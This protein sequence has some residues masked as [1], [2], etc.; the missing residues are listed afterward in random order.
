MAK[1]WER[2]YSNCLNPK[3]QSFNDIKQAFKIKSEN[4][5]GRLFKYKKVDVNSA[6]D[7]LDNVVRLSLPTDFNDPYDCAINYNEEK[8][9]KEIMLYDHEISNKSKSFLTPSE[10]RQIKRSDRPVDTF[11][12]IVKSL[13][14]EYKG[15]LN[16][17]FRK[18]RKMFKSLF[19][20]LDRINLDNWKSQIKISCFTENY[21]AKALPMWAYYGDNHKGYCLEYNFKEAPYY[22]NQ[23]FPVK[24]CN[25][26]FTPPFKRINELS[27]YIWPIISA[28]TKALNWKYEKEWR[29][30]YVNPKYE[31]VSIKPAAIYLGSNISNT[32][33]TKLIGVSKRRDLKIYKCRSKNGDFELDIEELTDMEISELI[34]KL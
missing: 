16:D 26:Y 18:L 20:T 5:P 30:I 29:L 23:L 13:E 25:H 21:P 22:S 2:Q 32:N 8:Q 33:M 11:L 1:N 7:I 10:I 9:F 27:K 14:P 31:V 12:E 6:K 28:T 34:N 3:C 24:Y 17:H 4:I 19:E 15:L